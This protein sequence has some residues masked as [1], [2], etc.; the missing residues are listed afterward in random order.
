M[1][2]T[3]NKL[4]AL[5]LKLS[6]SAP[7]NRQSMVE[8]LYAKIADKKA[9]IQKLIPAI[10]PEPKRPKNVLTADDAGPM[11]IAAAKKNPTPKKS[12]P[13]HH[14]VLTVQEAGVA[15]LRSFKKKK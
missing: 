10:A 11:V 2:K 4:V 3:S 14:G 12:A 6:E 5:E 8:S 7:E 1:K 15:M 9:A 13:V